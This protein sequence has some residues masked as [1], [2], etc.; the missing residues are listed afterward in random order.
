MMMMNMNQTFMMNWNLKMFKFTL[1]GIEFLR[2]NNLKE[3]IERNEESKMSHHKLTKQQ[4]RF[5]KCVM[6]AHYNTFAPRTFGNW[7]RLCWK[8]RR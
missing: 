6:K 4:K 8:G 7:M 5:Q 2:N 3:R 1:L